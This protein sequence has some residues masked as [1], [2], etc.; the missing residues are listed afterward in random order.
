MTPETPWRTSLCLVLVWSRDDDASLKERVLQSYPSALKALENHFAKA[1]GSVT[2]LEEHGIGK[3]I[4]IRVGG[5]FTF[6]SSW[7]DL[8]KVTRV[9]MLTTM[10]DQKSKGPK[11]MV[12]CFNKENSFWLLKEEGKSEFTVKS[13]DTN[14]AEQS[15]VKEQMDFWLYSY[16]HA[17][18]SI[19]GP[20]MSSLIADGGAAIER[21]SLVRRD[22]KTHLKIAFDFKNGANKRLRSLAGWVLVAPEE[23]WV[24]HE[25]EFTDTI[26]MWG[27]RV[28]YA[29]P[30]DGFPVPKR[31]VS[32]RSPL[33]GRPPTDIDT[34]E[35]K[36]LHFADVPDSEFRLS[37]F[38]LPD[39]R[40]SP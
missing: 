31:V 9:A 13:L 14:K 4:H 8:G 3:P 1:F 24:I 33:R 19:G 11:E 6:A 37:A 38:G 22:D 16:L 29:Q 40:R 36:E 21:V 28:E 30:Q 10:N 25:Y 15:F 34:Y 20:S 35:F 12:F 18:F 17:P 39:A 5:K 26:N 27:G 7:P 2:G 23:K 32:T